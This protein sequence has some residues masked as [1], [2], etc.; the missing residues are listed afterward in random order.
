MRTFS[1]MAEE[2]MRKN[3]PT[4]EESCL[5]TEATKATEEMRIQDMD[6]PDVLDGLRQPFLNWLHSG[7]ILNSRWSTALPSLHEPFLDWCIETGYVG[8]DATM[9]ELMALE[10]GLQIAVVCGTTLVFGVALKVDV[11]AYQA[12]HREGKE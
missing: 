8:C 1:D 11:E 10:C 2:W 4:T 7:C 6:G 9:F 12:L 5:A 3:M